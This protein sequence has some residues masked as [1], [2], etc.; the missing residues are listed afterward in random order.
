MAGEYLSVPA[1]APPFRQKRIQSAG[2]GVHLTSIFTG[3]LPASCSNWRTCIAAK[4]GQL[5][6]L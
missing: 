4:L 3:A 5:H 2:C 1:L 6:D